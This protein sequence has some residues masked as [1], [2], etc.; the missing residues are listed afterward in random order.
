MNYRII[1]AW[2]VLLVFSTPVL[3]ITEEEISSNLNCP[4]GGGCTMLVSDCQMD[5]ALEMRETVRGMIAE[6]MSEKKIYKAL[7][8]KYGREVFATPPKEGFDW[9]VWLALPAGIIAGGV[10]VYKISRKR[11]DDNEIFEYEYEQFLQERNK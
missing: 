10:V 11:M 7:E 2:F 6:G 5:S 8:A 9:I 4:E 1:A 3:A